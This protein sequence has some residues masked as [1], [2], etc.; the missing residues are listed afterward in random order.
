MQFL[1]VCKR[2]DTHFH[3]HG[4]ASGDVPRKYHTKAYRIPLRNQSRSVWGKLPAFPEMAIC[5]HTNQNGENNVNNFRR[6]CAQRMRHKRRLL[7]KHHSAAPDRQVGRPAEHQCD[8][9]QHNFQ[10]PVTSHVNAPCKNPDCAENH[11]VRYR[12]ISHMPS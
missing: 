8:A 7:T 12:C 1:Y 6:E 4:H 10:C 9:A 2:R 3:R 11:D 5:C